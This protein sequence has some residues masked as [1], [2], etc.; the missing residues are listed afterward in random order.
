MDIRTKYV[1]AEI[2]NS[3]LRVV[4]PKGEESYFEVKF[5]YDNGFTYVIGDNDL[6]TLWIQ[7]QKGTHTVSVDGERIY[8]NKARFHIDQSTIASIYSELGISDK[9]STIILNADISI[10]TDELLVI[11]NSNSIDTINIIIGGLE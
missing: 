2:T 9:S 7:D 4:I 11:P 5:S 8:Y 10:K 6:V 1:L 3:N